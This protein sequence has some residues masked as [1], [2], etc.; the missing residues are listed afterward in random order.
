MTTEQDK[1]M[2][3][4]EKHGRVTSRGTNFNRPWWFETSFDKLTALLTDHRQQVIEELA[5]KTG[6]MPQPLTASQCKISSYAEGWQDCLNECSEAIAAM[7]ARV[8]ISKDSAKIAQYTVSK[9]QAR[10]EQLENALETVSKHSEA[11]GIIKMIARAA[12]KGAS[13]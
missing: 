10:V 12:M 9:L 7:Q 11:A 2:A 6:V 5:G 13:K 1:A 3:L 8:E 4:A